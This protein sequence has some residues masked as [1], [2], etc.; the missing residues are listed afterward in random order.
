MASILHSHPMCHLQTC[1]HD[2][3]HYGGSSSKAFPIR[4]GVKQVCAL[5]PTLFGI[6]FYMLLSYAFSSSS[7]GVWY[8]RTDGKLFNLARLRSKTQIRLFLIRE[9]FFADDAALTSRTGDGLQGLV[10]QLVQACTEC[11][12]TISPKKTNRPRSQRT[13]SH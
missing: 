7:D 8:T 12:L 6:F 2:T 10:D 4:N 1:M 3:V 5:A 13:S 11:V 9:M